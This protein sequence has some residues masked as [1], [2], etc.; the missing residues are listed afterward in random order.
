LPKLINLQFIRIFDSNKEPKKYA[1]NVNCYNLQ[2]L[3]LYNMPLDIATNIIKNT[4]GNLWK[5]KIRIIDYCDK[6]KEYNQAIHK[7]CPNI[8]YVTVY[9]NRDGTLLEEL[10]NIFIKCGNTTRYI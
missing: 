4:N 3:E 5:I 10:E 1:M 6:S 8:K 7:Y 9:L 2:I